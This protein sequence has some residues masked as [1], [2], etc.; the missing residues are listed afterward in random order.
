MT[1]KIVGNVGRAN[2]NATVEDL[3]GN[4]PKTGA[5]Y[6][7]LRTGDLLA[8]GEDTLVTVDKPK[9]EEKYTED[10]LNSMNMKELR[11]IGEPLG[12]KDTKKSEL[13]AEILEMQ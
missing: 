11:K 2:S 5:R 12:A 1:M 10:E 8:E 9:E 4:V 6:L 13:I 3:M 7:D